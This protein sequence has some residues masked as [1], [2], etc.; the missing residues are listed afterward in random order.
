MACRGTSCAHGAVSVKRHRGKGGRA[1]YQVRWRDEGLQRAR[2]FD[3]R[4]DALAFEAE[5]RRREQLG[6]HAPAEPRTARGMAG[7]VVDARGPRMG[8]SRDRPTLGR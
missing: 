1:R 4:R 6:A 5:R 3:R 7:D 8:P 2:S